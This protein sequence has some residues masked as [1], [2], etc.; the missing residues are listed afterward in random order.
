ML[1]DQVADRMCRATGDQSSSS[2]SAR[3]RR[4]YHNLYREDRGRQ[5][6]VII[7]SFVGDTSSTSFSDL[8]VAGSHRHI[9]FFLAL[10]HFHLTSIPFGRN[11][12]G[13]L[14][15]GRCNFA[16]LTMTGLNE[17]VAQ[18]KSPPSTAD[19]K[20]VVRIRS[21]LTPEQIAALPNRFD[22]FVLPLDQTC[23][24]ITDSRVLRRQCTNAVSDTVRW[25]FLYTCEEGEHLRKD[26]PER[27][28]VCA[29]NY[30][31][32]MFPGRA[33]LWPYRLTVP[34]QFDD[35]LEAMIRG[36]LDKFGVVC[37]PLS[38]DH[39][40]GY[41]SQAATHLQTLLKVPVDQTLLS[42]DFFRNMD[43]AFMYRNP[44]LTMSRHFH[45]LTGRSYY[46]GNCEALKRVFTEVE[47]IVQHAFGHGSKPVWACNAE[48]VVQWQ[49][50]PRIND[51]VVT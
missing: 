36:Q 18:V 5:M 11:Q 51:I 8:Y 39:I 16:R 2:S 6:D 43:K 48:I 15:R 27:S 44:G 28:Y 50:Q 23:L 14:I 49:H 17:L 29:R 41:T 13:N 42:V 46:G 21:A 33:L 24:I 19:T 37:I 35:N 3:S 45:E 32:V 22:A 30:E 34:L 31:R 10:N 40:M 12:K 7:H 9:E 4:A 47:F 20:A 38:R 1:P 25:K 26:T